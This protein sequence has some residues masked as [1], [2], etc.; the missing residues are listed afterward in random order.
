MNILVTGSN[1][2]VGENL[3]KLLVKKSSNN[4]FGISRSKAILK[5]F[6]NF[7]HYEISITDPDWMR[8]IDNK[9]DAVIYLAQSDQYRKFP[10]GAQSMFDVNVGALLMTAEWARKN[11]VQQ[12][13]FAST[14]NVYKPTKFKL[15][16]KN[17]CKPHSFYGSSKLAG[18]QVLSH[19]SNF[20]DVTILR[21]FGV[22]G[23]GQTN[24]LVPNILTNVYKERKITLASG[25]GLIFTPIYIDDIV[26]I[27]NDLLKLAKTRKIKTFNVSG[28]EIIHLSDLV[29][30]ASE[31]FNIKPHI[32]ITEDE[33]VYLIA[34]NSK[35]RNTLQLT[36]K[37]SYKQGI[38][39]TL[40][41]FN[42]ISI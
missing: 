7:K 27:I 5:R 25:S 39:K 26:R 9:I 1:G 31:F 8:L 22:Y 12:F 36:N 16:E 40:Q 42:K 41:H 35:I 38:N 34:D 21:I 10:E 13:I 3:V 14:G 30:K 19:F 33:P 28:D 15:N 20:F 37:V 2:F 24:M 4:I 29:F 23:P 17:I 11:N 32:E 6:N 18:E